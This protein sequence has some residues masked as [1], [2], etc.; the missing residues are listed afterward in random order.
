M[1]YMYME[2]ANPENEPCYNKQVTPSSPRSIVINLPG[3]GSSRSVS[4]FKSDASCHA[5]A[6]INPKQ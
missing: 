4:S 3:A 2:L 6:E 1:I 5:R